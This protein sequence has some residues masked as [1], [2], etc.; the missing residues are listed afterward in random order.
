MPVQIKS[1]TIPECVT[2]DFSVPADE[3]DGIALRIQKSN[4]RLTKKMIDIEKRERK[5][6][7]KPSTRY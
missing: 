5:T 2:R 6:W 7:Q 1:H 4:R 3:I